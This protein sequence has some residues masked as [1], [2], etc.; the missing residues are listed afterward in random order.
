MNNDEN[1]NP[2]ENDVVQTDE[3]KIDDI[4][5]EF[6]LDSDDKVITKTN[7]RKIAVY[8]IAFV[9]VIAL[10]S[11]LGY[12][13][14]VSNPVKT[15]SKAYMNTMNDMLSSEGVFDK[16]ALSSL[17]TTQPT[18]SELSLTYKTSIYSEYSKLEGSGITA[19]LLY[20]PETQEAGGTID[21]S[22]AGMP[23]NATE[24]Y[25]D[26]ESIFGMIPLLENKWIEINKS[27]LFSSYNKSALSKYLGNFEYTDDLSINVFDFYDIFNYKGTSDLM[28]EYLQTEND[29]FNA[30][31]ANMSVIKTNNKYTLDNG[32]KAHGYSVVL[33]SA[34]IAAVLNGFSEYAEEQ[35]DLLPLAE[36]LLPL[37]KLYG[38]NATAEEIAESLNK[39]KFSAFTDLAAYIQNK[40]YE[41]TVYVYKNRLVRIESVMDLELYEG[42]TT[43]C[44]IILSYPSGV[45]VTDKITVE[46]ISDYTDENSEITFSAEITNDGDNVNLSVYGFTELYSA[47][48]EI[49]ADASYSKST[50]AYSLKFTVANRDNTGDSI[51]FSS[52]GSMTQTEDSFSLSADDI[53]YYVGNALIIS[54]GL[55]LEVNPLSEEIA[56]PEGETVNLFTESDDELKAL[57]DE[58]KSGYENLKSMVSLL[59]LE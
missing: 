36:Q 56:K 18:E 11:Y 8:I 2:L 12:N 51:S 53:S 25:A 38:G 31:A 21:A 10:V 45:N 57:V 49:T 27:N 41:F 3:N 30:L 5:F 43:P 40:E 39:I 26:S 16:E 19:N 44:K 17:I 46:F 59:G 14:S 32:K 22:V 42:T 13:F 15:V 23:V 34:D 52:D 55:D 29:A 20:N 9:A 50:F 58:I 47:P 24:Y 35:T 54:L 6:D 28:Q 33:R 1:K 7:R 48:Y 37:F 4:N